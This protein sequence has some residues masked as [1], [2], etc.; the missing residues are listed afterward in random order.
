VSRHS[1]HPLRLLLQ[2]LA[3]L[4]ATAAC[5]GTPTPDPPDFLP[6]PNDSL[7]GATIFEDASTQ[8]DPVLINVMGEPGAVE[9]SSDVWI[10]NLDNE[11]LPP[12]TTRARANGS[13]GPVELRVSVGDRVRLVVRTAEQHSRPL[14]FEVVEANIGVGLRR[15]MD[16]S[17][18]CLV[19]SPP[20]E[21]SLLDQGSILLTNECEAAVSL[22]DA[23]LRF[24]DQGFTL[25]T[26]GQSL[27]VGAELRIRVT[28][29]AQRPAEQADI[30]LLDAQSGTS[31]GR[32]AIGLWGNE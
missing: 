21:L 4:C 5:T 17:L 18:K 1:T 22:G 26:L 13:F 15:L 3:P 29:E 23:R 9:A 10:V 6:D 12:V 25:G 16:T 20:A 32:Y 30:L 2:L 28:Y 14:D 7:I 11:Q 27:A 31:T 24:G 19:V 8:S